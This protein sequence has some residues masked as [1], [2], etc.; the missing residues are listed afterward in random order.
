MEGL[1]KDKEQS[2]L[3]L[4]HY[5]YY[6]E[7]HMLVLSRIF[8]EILNTKLTDT[9]QIEA[10]MSLHQSL[11]HINL[12]ANYINQLNIDPMEIINE[13]TM[14]TLKRTKQTLKDTLNQI[15][16]H[17]H[18]YLNYCK[19]DIKNILNLLEFHTNYYCQIPA[20]IPPS[21]PWFNERFT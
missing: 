20:F 1:R 19:R 14:D 13:L 12:F 11:R 16:M 21:P 17:D 18:I 3:I 8:H 15:D 4:Q 6:I 7:Q 9:K 10:E 2:Q 5:F